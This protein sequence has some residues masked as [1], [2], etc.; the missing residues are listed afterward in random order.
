LRLRQACGGL[1]PRNCA[2][3]F[4]VL[5]VAVLVVVCAVAAPPSTTLPEAAVGRPCSAEA[6]L[7]FAHPRVPLP[8]PLPDVGGLL[9]AICKPLP[10]VE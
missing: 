9:V 4:V 1:T 7:P 2:P 5:V 8:P 10:V 3:E 6:L